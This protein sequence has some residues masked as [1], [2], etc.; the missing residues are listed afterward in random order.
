MP[1]FEYHC[2][3]CEGEFQLL[4]LKKQEEEQ[5]VCPVCGSRSLKKLISRVVFHVGEQDRI[6]A[7]DPSAKKSD[8][9]YRDS[10]NIGLEAKK[11]AQQMGLNLGSDFETK[12]E[13]LR[14]DPGSVLKDGE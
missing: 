14:T 10:R 8:A 7:F 4:I 5:L 13:K 11:R 3:G 2:H 6:D 12:L 9:F 1:I